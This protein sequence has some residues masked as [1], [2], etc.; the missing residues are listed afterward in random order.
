MSDSRHYTTEYPL[1]KSLLERLAQRKDVA[2]V[3]RIN[4]GLLPGARGRKIRV[5]WPGAPDILGMLQGGRL[6][7]FECKSE[8]G[9]VRPT[10]EAFIS[11]IARAGGVAAVIRSP[12][13]AI[14][15]LD[16]L[17]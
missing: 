15:L 8:K 10:Q 7:C 2:F 13:E 16:S 9:A 11:L 3:H 5:G 6:F 17:R 1:V 12:E 14:E 4:S